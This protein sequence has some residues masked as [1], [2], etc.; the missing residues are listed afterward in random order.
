MQQEEIA[1]VLPHWQR[2]K[3]EEAWKKKKKK[4]SAELCRN[5]RRLCSVAF[6]AYICPQ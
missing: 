6:R 5:E 1:E 2:R 3:D 4:N